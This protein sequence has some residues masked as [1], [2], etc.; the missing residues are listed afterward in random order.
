MAADWDR[1]PA[2]VTWSA[3][4]SSLVV[5]ADDAGRRP[6]FVV[7]PADVVG[8]PGDRR[9]LQL[10]RRLRRTRRRALRAAQFVFVTAA[11]GAHRPR[12]H[13]HRCCRASKCH[14]CQ[15]NSSEVTAVSRRWHHRAVVA[16]AARRRRPAPLVLWIHGGPLGSWNTWHWRWNPWLLT[17]RGY[18]VLMP[19]PALSTGYGQ[20]FIQRGWGAWGSAPY[21]DLMAATDAALAHPGVDETRAA[22]M[23]GSFGGYMANWIAGQ[24]DRFDA[25]V[26]HAS[27][28]ALDQ[29]G[30][31]T[32]GA[33]WW[34]RE[35]TSRDGRAELAASTRRRDLHPDTGDPWRQGLPG[36][37]RRGPATVVRA[38]DA[39]RRCPQPTTA[40]ART[41]FCTSRPRGTGCSRPSTPRSGTRSSSRSSVAT[42]SAR[43][44]S[45]R[46]RSG[47]ASR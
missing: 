15:A 36:T 2:S 32:D 44:W 22:A 18:A 20:D 40:P 5:T 24:T 9:R 17:A 21:T 47:E 19:D 8:D 27:L 31:T 1:W 35:M 43:T 7:D 4:G 39:V 12:R 23:G 14:R 6:V 3:D 26:T 10:R 13:D 38:A 11:P 42:C 45:F 46:K 33:Y 37:D 34:A 25:I 30:P 41:G 29:F 28:W 16:D